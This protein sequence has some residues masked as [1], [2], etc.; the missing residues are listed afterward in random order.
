MTSLFTDTAGNS[1]F[2]SRK[3]AL[4]FSVPKLVRDVIQTEDG[5]C[6]KRAGDQQAAEGMESSAA[7]SVSE[8]NVKLSPLPGGSTSH[9]KMMLPRSSVD[10]T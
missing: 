5:Q 10:G 9:R 6:R 8:K 4:Q 2:L 7:K 1:P 3:E